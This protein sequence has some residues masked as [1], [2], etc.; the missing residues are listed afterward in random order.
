MTMLLT[1]FGSRLK[2]L[3]KLLQKPKQL[4]FP[5]GVVEQHGYH[6]PLV[7]DTISGV[8]IAR[9]MRM[10]CDWF[11]IKEKTIDSPY[12]ISN[13]MQRKEIKVGVMGFKEKL[14]FNL[15]R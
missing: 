4:L 7:T 9:S 5:I 6:L 11:E 3:R 8:E 1:Q 13:A 14:I 10:D 2:S 12:I 15:V